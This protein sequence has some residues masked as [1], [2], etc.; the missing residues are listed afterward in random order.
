MSHK[1]AFTLMEILLVVAVIAILAGI[2]I[3]AINPSRQLANTRNSQR[4]V[5]VD[6]INKAIYQYSIDRGALPA[7]VSTTPLEICRT[8]A[9]DCNG[10]ADFAALTD[11]AIYLN[12]LPVDP[13][14]DSPNG[15]GYMVCQTPFGRPVVFSPLAELGQDIRSGNLCG[16]YQIYHSIYGGSLE[17]RLNNMVVSGEYVY[18]SGRTG[19]EGAGGFDSILMKFNRYNMGL[20]ARRIYGG[21]GN[22]QAPEI[23]VD[24]DHVYTVGWTYSAGG[25]ESDGWVIKY[26]KSDLAVID[27]K[28]YGGA[29][30]DTFQDLAADSDYLYITGAVASQ[31]QGGSDIVLIKYRKS[32]LSIVASKLYGGSGSESGSAIEIDQNYI[33]VAGTTNSEG[34]GG[35]DILLLKYDRNTLALLDKK[36]YGGSGNDYVYGIGVDADNVYLP[37]TN[38]SEGAGSTEGLLLKYDKTSLN[39]VAK[40]IYGGSGVDQFSYVALDDAYVYVIGSNTSE[41]AGGA[42]AMILKYNKSDLSLA[43]RKIYGSTL[44]DRFTAAFSSDNYL[45]VSGN[46]YSYSYGNRDIWGLKVKKDL[47]TGTFSSTPAGFTFRDSN[48]TA[49]DSN[50]TFGNSN[51]TAATSTLSQINADLTSTSSNLSYKFYYVQ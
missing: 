51:L 26:N 13:R 33:Y 4:Y 18:A 35:Y 34:A 19:S 8:G 32:D 5:D 42:D 43:A 1:K 30:A 31:G 28:F 7:T 15:T 36:I 38:N 46:G 12:A 20:V 9:S 49:A 24:N 16:D 10:L 45:W 2:V 39:I 47:A 48:L 41:G 23:Y 3:L 22:D 50:L 11:N 27:K 44:E 6:T 25:G 21:A 29:A 40:K 14:V 37:C 17:D